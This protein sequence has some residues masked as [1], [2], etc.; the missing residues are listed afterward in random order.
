MSQIYFSERK[1]K[2][3]ERGEEFV[4]ICYQLQQCPHFLHVSVFW[5]QAQ[6]LQL[7]GRREQTCGVCS[8][9]AVQSEQTDTVLTSLF[10][11]AADHMLQK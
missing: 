10:L 3:E 4:L 2:R 7:T 6:R 9:K 5:L 8:D 11:N 1:R